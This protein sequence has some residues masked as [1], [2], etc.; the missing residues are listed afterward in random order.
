MAVVPAADVRPPL[1]EYYFEAVDDRGLPVAS[2]G[3]VAA[4][5][6][7]AVPEEGSSVLGSWWFWTGVGL[8][9]AGAVTAALLLAGGGDGEQQG[10]FIVTVF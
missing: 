3:D 1:V 9:V 5:L 8:V 7:I 4:P 10:T 6:R 2:R